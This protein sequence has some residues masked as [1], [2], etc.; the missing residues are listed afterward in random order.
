MKTEKTLTF[1]EV[2]AHVE[3]HFTEHHLKAMT[4]TTPSLCSIY[5]IAR[6]I[7]VLVSQLFFIPQKWRDVVK[8]LIESLDVLC[9]QDATDTTTGTT[10]AN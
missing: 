10:P 5:S 3:K 7:L 2:N 1:E 9:P 6:P 8:V 4:A